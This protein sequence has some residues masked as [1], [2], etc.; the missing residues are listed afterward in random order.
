M[1]PLQGSVYGERAEGRQLSL[2]W[3]CE[4][5]AGL[6][7]CGHSRLQF[8]GVTRQSLAGFPLADPTKMLHIP[9]SLSPLDPLSGFRLHSQG[10]GIPWR[11]FRV[12]QVGCWSKQ[13]DSG[14]PDPAWTRAALIYCLNLATF[15]KSLLKRDE[16][17]TEFTL[18][19]SRKRGLYPWTECV[20]ISS[21]PFCPF[22]SCCPFY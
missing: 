19:E 17:H 20:H 8:P 7:W 16:T 5:W 15:H 21:Y 9:T 10:P 3:R 22:P 6:L 13:L 11:R 1:N 18:W 4:Q 14:P 2:Y 12:G